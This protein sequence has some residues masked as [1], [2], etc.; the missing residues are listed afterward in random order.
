ERWLRH[1]PIRARRISPIGR[2]RKWLQRNPTT[3]GIGILSLA[4]TA[5]L[6]AI[7][8]NSGV[9]RQPR[10]AGIAVLPFENLSNDR[11]DASFADGVQDDLLTKLAKIASLKVISRNSVMGYQGK[12]NAH[13]IANALSVSHLLEGS[14]RKTGAWIHIHTQ[15][16]DAR[17]DA[18]VWAEEYDRDVKD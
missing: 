13:E 8:W 6:A 14:V 3:A 7:I 4:L 12:H 2:A 1:E 11:E 18:H 10:T 17:T 15:L 5:A 16:I 9:L